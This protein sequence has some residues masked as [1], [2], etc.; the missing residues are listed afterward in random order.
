MTHYRHLT[1]VAVLQGGTARPWALSGAQQ[2]VSLQYKG[3]FD[4]PPKLLLP[5]ALLI[6]LV[7]FLNILNYNYV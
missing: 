3:S 2:C 1:T 4:R 5:D 7:H 6:G